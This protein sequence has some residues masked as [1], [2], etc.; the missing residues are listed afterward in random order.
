[1]N[2]V[3]CIQSKKAYY[4]AVIQSEAKPKRRGSSDAEC[5]QSESL[6]KPP[7]S[8]KRNRHC[9]RKAKSKQKRERERK[10]EKDR[11]Q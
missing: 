4:E 5:I 9:L 11:E 2:P 8:W 3:E 1:M 10:K 7:F 6:L